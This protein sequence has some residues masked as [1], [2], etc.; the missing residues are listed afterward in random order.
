MSPTIFIELPREV[1]HAARMT[2]DEMKRELAITL[3]EQGRLSF[4]KARELAGLPIGQFQQLLGARGICVH[5]DVD[6]YRE[7]LATLAELGDV[8]AARK[9]HPPTLRP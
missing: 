7:D 5:Y 1:L 4:G 3:Y 6:D 2:S 9:Q 8:E